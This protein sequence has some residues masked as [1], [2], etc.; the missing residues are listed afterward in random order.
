MTTELFTDGNAMAGP[1]REIFAVDLTRASGACAGCGQVGPVA[2]LHLY[3]QAPGMVARCPNCGEVVMRYVRGR[4]R[5]WL[6][7]RGVVALEIPLDTA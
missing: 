1:L 2:A 7:M 6:D 3:S 4:D 5:A